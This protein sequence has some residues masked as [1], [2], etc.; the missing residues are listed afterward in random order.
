M[1]VRLK[2]SAA[3]HPG[4]GPVLKIIPALDLRGGRVVRLRQGDYARETGYDV[5]A[6]EQARKY[7]DAGAT[8]LH[9]VDLDGARVGSFENLGVIESLAGLGLELQ[10]GGGVRSEADL[11]R[12]FD[13]GVHRVV[14][15]SV[16]I[17]DPDRV[18]EWISNNGADRLV[19][20]LDTRQVEGHW[21]L[22][23]AGWTES[24]RLTLDDLAP[25]YESNG[26]R[27]LLCTD[28]ERDGM[29]SGPNLDLYTHLSRIAPSLSVQASGGVRDQADVAALK[30]MV[31]GV[32]LG[33]SLLEGRL[34]LGGALARTLHD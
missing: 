32:I 22:S 16:A 17:K 28:I 31:D 23:S 15:G 21:Q 25:R 4:E 9:V 29:L 11:R 27:H 18:I 14:V 8:R 5:D 33:R 2:Q 19:I 6:L 34:D 12:L 30:G 20:A 3:M 13:I 10:A 7:R 26:A 24:A 1:N